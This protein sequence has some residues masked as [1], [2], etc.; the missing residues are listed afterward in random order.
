LAQILPEKRIEHREIKTRQYA[1]VYTCILFFLPEYI[2]FE[3][4]NRT[5]DKLKGKT[6][7]AVMRVWPDMLNCKMSAG[8]Q[9]K[10]LIY[11]AGLMAVIIVLL[12]MFIVRGCGRP[13]EAKE[14]VKE[15]VTDSVVKIKLYNADT[16]TIEEVE[17]EEYIKCVVAAEMPAD[18]HIEALKAQAVAARTFA[19]GRMA[20]VYRSKQGV[21]D[22]APVCTLSSHC[23]AWVSKENALKKW[24]PL[25]ATRNWNKI[26]KAVEETKGLI[27][28]YNGTIAN[29]L[30]HASSGGRTENAEEVWPGV[31]VPYLRSVVSEGEERS[32]DYITSIEISKSDFIEKFKQK[33]PGATFKKNLLDSIKIIDYTTGGRVNTLEIGNIILRGT[34]FRTL[35]GLRSA[36]FEISKADDDNMLK[37]TTTGFGHGVGMSQWGA[38]SLAKKGGTFTEILQH[39]YT[40]V[41]IISINEFDDIK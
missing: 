2:Y 11:Y 14:P 20:G 31:S 27:V 15:K 32:K 30:F 37:I 4:N 28:V 22:D 8:D 9:M 33:Y 6:A 18:F 34:E 38:D 41:N 36:R 24:S 13:E 26:S 5:N 39:Y 35:F 25:F 40:G 7:F 3:A 23:Q 16:E 21:H 12:P 19:F 10:K 17:L 29:T 1:G